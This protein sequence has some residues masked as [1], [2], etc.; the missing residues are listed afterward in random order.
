MTQDGLTGTYHAVLH[1]DV[2]DKVAKRELRAN[3]HACLP[4]VPFTCE[5][6]REAATGQPR[7]A[8]NHD[9]AQVGIKAQYDS[10]TDAAALTTVPP[11]TGP[12]ELKGMRPSP[13]K[14]M[15][16]TRAGQV[17]QPWP[18]PPPDGRSIEIEKALRAAVD[19]FFGLAGENV[20][21]AVAM[22]MGQADMDW[23]LGSFSQAIRLTAQLIQQYMPPL[24]GARIAGTEDV[25][26]ANRADVRGLFDFS[27]AFDVRGLDIK[28]AKEMLGF[29]SEMILPM[30]NRGD[31]NRYPL[32]ESGFNVL[33]STLGPRCLPGQEVSQQ[34]QLD[35]E[36]A[37]LAQI[38]SGAPTPEV[39]MGIDFGGRAQVMFEDL[40]RS[41]ERQGALMSSVQIFQVY[42][43][44]LDA[45]I[46]NQKQHQGANAAAGKTLSK[47]PMEPQSA[48]EKLLNFLKSLK[49]TWQ[50]N[51]D[52]LMAAMP[53][54]QQT[55][56]SIQ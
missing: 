1:A 12:D 54:L 46:D 52:E 49:V 50:T 55:L 56:N 27:V 33:D 48:P 23:F 43:S 6:D 2:Q 36:R 5:M 34:R 7:G 9:V 47:D 26:T 32:L 17:V 8:R 10:R 37:V 29:V 44:R 30:D 53:Y 51:P 31:I 24:K 20:S 19:R 21:D 15:P 39:V 40:Q 11:W 13:G 35:E 41:P 22:M 25:V 28:W 4:F 38:F 14:F 18:M 45:L 3:W 16:T 42:T